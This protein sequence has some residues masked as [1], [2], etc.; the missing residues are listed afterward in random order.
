MALQRAAVGKAADPTGED[1][2]WLR[3]RGLADVPR[4]GERLRVASGWEAAVEAALGDL[5][6]AVAVE[7]T[8]GLANDL[9]NLKGGRI[10]IYEARQSSP[11]DGEL[12]PLSALVESP[13]GS[14]LDGVFA[15]DSMANRPGAPLG[16]GAG[17]ERIVTRGGVLMGA[18]WIRGGTLPGAE[19]QRRWRLWR[20]RGRSVK[21][22]NAQEEA[23]VRSAECDARLG[24]TRDRL[25]ALEGERETLQTHHA[26][27]TEELSRVTR[28]HDV[29]QVRM[30]EA[31]ARARRNAADREE[32]HA[33]IDDE[34]KL[35]EDYRARLA[36]LI[37]SAAQLRS[38]AESSPA[39]S[40]RP[41]SG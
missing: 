19:D 18:D 3:E 34:S 25:L 16:A 37:Q 9:A 1:A 11:S 33:Q 39:R 4:L 22:K 6:D 5:L 36:E 28:E 41:G 21:L 14:L 2:R 31:D 40:S 12:R 38:E 29:R 23:E 17:C 27:A 26:A 8:G 35:L 20:G 7:D 13:V 24:E 10:S 15:A 32:I 30:E